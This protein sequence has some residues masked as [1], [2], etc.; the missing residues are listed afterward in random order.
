MSKLCGATKWAEIIYLSSSYLWSISLVIFI[1]STWMMLGFLPVTMLF[2]FLGLIRSRKFAVNN[3]CI[4]LIHRHVS[5]AHLHFSSFVI[6]NRSWFSFWQNG[7]RCWWFSERTSSLSG[8]LPRL[9]WFQCPIP[10]KSFRSVK[11]INVTFVTFLVRAGCLLWKKRKL[12][13]I[14][15][16]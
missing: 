1:C 10:T 5:V 7:C 13:F 16:F 3:G 2:T 15:F 6:H 9:P 14:W 8:W 11:F 12:L 4:I